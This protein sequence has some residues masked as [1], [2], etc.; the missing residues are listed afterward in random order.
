MSRIRTVKPEFWTSEQVMECS[1][2]AR[3]AF[4][5]LWNFCDD[6]GVHPASCKTLKAEVFPADDLTAADV[7]ALANE[8][9]QQ[10][11][12]IE[13]HAAGR[14]WWFVTGWHHQL[15]N[16]PSKSRYPLPPCQAPLPKAAGPDTDFDDGTPEN[17]AIHGKLMDDSLSTH[18]GLTEDSLT[19]GKGREGR[20]RERKGGERKGE[21]AAV[22]RKTHAPPKTPFPV[23]F[24][25]TPEIRAWAEQQGYGDLAAHLDAFRDKATAKGYQYADWGAAFRNAVRDDWAHL[26]SGNAQSPRNGQQPSQS[27]GL[28]HPEAREFETILQNLHRSVIEGEVIHEA[29]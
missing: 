19:E 6:H 5:G 13:F 23:H 10:A 3:L 2:L 18:G 20:G 12:L 16:R 4:I 21:D 11:L 17:T 15:I 22:P 27:M 14:A 26:R 8:L 9:L 1:P 28:D 24:A 7:Q 29:R 25:I